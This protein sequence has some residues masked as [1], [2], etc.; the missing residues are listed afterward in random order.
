MRL[1]LLLLIMMTMNEDSVCGTD[2]AVRAAV[3]GWSSALND[4]Q[5]SLLLTAA[6]GAGGRDLGTSRLLGSSA[7]VYSES[8]LL[9]DAMTGLKTKP[10]CTAPPYALLLDSSSTAFT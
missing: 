7:A 4:L 8:L 5:S 1:L 10:S 2:V 9:S 6:G 3:G